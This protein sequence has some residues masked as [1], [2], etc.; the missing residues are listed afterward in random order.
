MLEGFKKVS[1]SRGV[2]TL[3]IVKDGLVFNKNVAK[4]FG[5][6][7]RVLFLVNPEQKQIA[8]QKIDGRDDQSITFFRRMN[9]ARFTYRE[10]IHQV[11]A[12]GSFDLEHYYYKVKGTVSEE[13]KAI[14]FDIGEAVQKDRVFRHRGYYEDANNDDE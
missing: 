9:G 2:P 13:D 8:I 4:Y 11:M 10:L 6:R 3:A 7:N 12:L 5:E 1:P 14:I